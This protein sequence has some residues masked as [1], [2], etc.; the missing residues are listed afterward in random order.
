MKRVSGG[1]TAQERGMALL[2]CLVFLLLLTMIGLSSVQNA[3]LQEKMA[4]SLSLHNR[5]FQAA[6]TALRQGESLVRRHDYHLPVCAGPAQCAPPA[7]SAVL[8][9]ALING[10]SGVSWIA[11]GNGFYG[12]QNIG[13]SLDA[14]NLPSHTRATLY[15]VTAIGLVGP[16]R[17]VLESIYA[18]Y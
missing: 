8:S 13:T 3:T 6:E 17:S 7:E 14:V 18:K 1:G 9:A 12:V 16:A 5:A 2:L 10:V 15:R 11:T 4:A